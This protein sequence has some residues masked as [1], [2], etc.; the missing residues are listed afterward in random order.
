MKTIHSELT[1][2]ET[3]ELEKSIA[4]DLKV[5]DPENIIAKDKQEVNENPKKH[6]RGTGGFYDIS[7]LF[8]PCK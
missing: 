5:P 8:A 4:K 6:D 1:M 7:D 2:I 3:S